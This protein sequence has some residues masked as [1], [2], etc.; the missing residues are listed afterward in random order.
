MTTHKRTK[1]ALD[2]ES[3]VELRPHTLAAIH[4]GAAH[5]TLPPP[6]SNATFCPI[7]LRCEGAAQ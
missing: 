2:R 5:P 7:S 1:L 3:L 4:G 6:H